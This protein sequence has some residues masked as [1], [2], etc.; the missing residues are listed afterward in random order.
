[1]GPRNEE[2]PNL[3]LLIVV[4]TAS[5]DNFRSQVDSGG[6]MSSPPE[7]DQKLEGEHL[8]FLLKDYELKIRFLSDHYTRIWT[9]F[10]F[11]IAAETALTVASVT[12]L[13]DK[14]RLPGPVAVAGLAL[15]LIWYVF[16]AQDRYLVEVYRGQVHRVGRRLGAH[17]PPEP[18]GTTGALPYEPVG[19][20]GLR[21]VPARPWQWRLDP[22]STTK[23]VAWMPIIV[24]MG[25]GFVLLA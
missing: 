2:T 23:L 21:R 11:F 20:T 18:H 1:M 22:I 24:A 15:S 7:T 14:G 16:G 3:N 9:R 4:A 5:R 10:N 12:F 6:P 17:W 13:K 25:W 8:A 19:D